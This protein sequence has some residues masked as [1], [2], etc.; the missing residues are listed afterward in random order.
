[1]IWFGLVAFFVRGDLLATV[2]DSTFA[3]G[4]GVLLIALNL[5]R[6]FLR[7]RLSVLTIGL[8]TLLLIVFTPVVLLDIDREQ[9]TF[10]PALLII[11]GLALVIGALRT[12][13]FQTL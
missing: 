7:V 9:V 3:L 10:L 4:T 6:S 8:G 12:R 2:N 5:V 1:M 13:N 11:A